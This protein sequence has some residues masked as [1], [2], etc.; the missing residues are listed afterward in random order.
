MT[1]YFSIRLLLAAAILALILRTELPCW[2]RRYMEFM[3]L[4]QLLPQA[5]MSSAWWGYMWLPLDLVQTALCWAVCRELFLRQTRYRTFW[6]ERAGSVCFASCV[7]AALV[8]AAWHWEPR[9]VF[10]IWL[11]SRQYWRMSLAVGWASVSAWYGILRPLGSTGL[12]PVLLMWA[13]WLVSQ[14]VM[15]TTGGSCLLWRFV[16]NTIS[17]YWAVSNAGMLAQFVAVLRCAVSMR[18]GDTHEQ[19][20]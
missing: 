10:H 13:V 5:L 15:S 14:F 17:W 6:W 9:S 4:Y 1:L 18:K 2:T 16:P 12:E 8:L 11:L 19:H 3:F 7:A 20:A